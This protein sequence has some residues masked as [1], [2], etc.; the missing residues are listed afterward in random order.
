LV[1]PDQRSSAFISGKS[2]GFGFGF[3]ISAILAIL[4]ILAIS[5]R[6]FVSFVVNVLAF[7]PLPRSSVFQGLV[8]LI[9]VHQR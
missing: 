4:A 9:S 1:F 7:P 2:F 3:S 5:L 8:F 6:S